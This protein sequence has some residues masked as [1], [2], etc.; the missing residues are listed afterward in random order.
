VSS[1]GN[2]ALRM[3]FDPLTGGVPGIFVAGQGGRV[4]SFLRIGEN[5]AAGI[6]GR[7]VSVNQN[8]SLNASDH[9]AFLAS[10]GGGKAL[11]AIFLASP[12]SGRVPGLGFRRA[13]PIPVTASKAP[14]PNDRIKLSML[15]DPGLLPPPSPGTDAAKPVRQRAITITVADTRGVLWTSTL[16][17]RDA[18]LRGRT[19]TKRRSAQGDAFQRLRVQFGRGGTVRIAAAS[20]PFNLSD[21]AQGLRHYDQNSAV[22]LEPPFVVRADV[23]EDGAS[24]VVPCTPK[25]L[26][27][28]CGG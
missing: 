26:R 9:L 24:V 1:N 10:I 3:G 23:G 8:V 25:G 18:K 20:K 7:I 28:R 16:A 22:I 6:N 4:R 13:K 5:G 11:S 2:M 15:L 14:K 12:A 21:K 19:L 17:A 27:F